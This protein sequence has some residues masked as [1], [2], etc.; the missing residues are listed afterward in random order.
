LDITPLPTPGGA[1][2]GTAADGK[3]ILTDEPDSLDP[4]FGKQP[5]RPIPPGQNRAPTRSGSTL[6]TSSSLEFA[7]NNMAPEQL[8]AFHENLDTRLQPFWSSALQRR[9]QLSI[10]PVRI[11]DV[12]HGLHERKRGNEPDMP[13]PDLEGE[14]L[15]RNVFSTD[16]QGLFSLKITVPWERIVSHG[17]SLKMVFD[18]VSSHGQEQLGEE[19]IGSRNEEKEKRGEKWGLYLKAEL[20]SE[21]GP[22]RLPPSA[23]ALPPTSSAAFT[24]GSLADSPRPVE[25]D[26]DLWDSGAN[27]FFSPNAMPFNKGSGGPGGG[28]LNLGSTSVTASTWSP[29]ASTGGIRVIS[30]LDDTVK[31]SNILGGAREVFRSVV[32]FNRVDPEVDPDLARRI[33]TLSVV[34]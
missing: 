30:D 26:A 13:E 31:V 12:Q 5:S 24:T 2:T 14:P 20:L 18:G 29:I 23:T 16:A 4:D 32:F 6:S 17:P 27:G 10:Y 19:E 22:H 21:G 9:V 11:P 33:G 8:R 25:L 15:M 1:G 3:K 34:Q 28:L 7:L